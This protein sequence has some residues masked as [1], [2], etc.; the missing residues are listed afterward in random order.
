MA[1]KW[2]YSNTDTEFIYD[3]KE[4]IAKNANEEVII[5]VLNNQRVLTVKKNGLEV[6]SAL[7]G[8]PKKPTDTPAHELDLLLEFIKEERIEEFKAMFKE[9]GNL[10]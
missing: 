8:P 3:Y 2:W 1:K 7:I 9:H 10:L 5:R 6:A 4:N